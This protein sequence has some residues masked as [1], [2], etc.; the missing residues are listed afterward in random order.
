MAPRIFA[1]ALDYI[2]DGRCAVP[3]VNALQKLLSV[4]SVL[5][6]LIHSLPLLQQRSKRIFLRTTAPLC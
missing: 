5:Q 3:D 2:Y 1:L 4:A 6:R